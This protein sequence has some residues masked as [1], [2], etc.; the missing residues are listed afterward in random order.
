MSPQTR[1]NVPGRTTRAGA[2]L[3]APIGRLCGRAVAAVEESVLAVASVPERHVGDTRT[4]V[5]GECMGDLGM[6]RSR[7]VEAS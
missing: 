2:S 7:S 3:R 1:D 5:F 6:I 4:A